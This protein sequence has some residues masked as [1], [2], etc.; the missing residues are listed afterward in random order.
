MKTLFSSILLISLLIQPAQEPLPA[1]VLPNPDSPMPSLFA[2]QLEQWL[3]D[4]QPGGTHIYAVMSYRLNMYGEFVSLAGLDP[5]TPPPYPWSL[6]DGTNLRWVGTLKRTDGQFALYPTS[7]EI[8]ASVHGAGPGGGAEISFPWQS[9]AKMLFGP[10]G[11]HGGGLSISSGVGIDWVGGN[12]L[13]AGVASDVVY[14]SAGGE[15]TSVCE[16][17]TSL[18]LRIEG[19]GNTFGYLHLDPDSNLEQGMTVSAGQALGSLKHGSFNDTCGWADQTANHY[20]L[21]WV[22]QPSAGKYLAEGWVLKDGKWTRGNQSVA[23]NQYMLGGSGTGGGDDDPPG[24][25]TIVVIPGE[26]V[27]G[28]G[29]R[30]WDYFIMAVNSAWGWV[31]PKMPN[32]D[33]NLARLNDQMWNTAKEIANDELETINVVAVNDTFYILPWFILAFL[34]LGFE[35]IKNMLYIFV[36]A[37]HTFRNLK[38]TFFI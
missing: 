16:D 10:R 28:G 18:G 23:V 13:G 17:G 5:E 1:L 11:V 19:G 9:G 38:Q 22:I 7:S 33:S 32:P 36:W 8:T 24:G 29:Y 25:S 26:D 31:K 21:H 3:T 30:I 14:A 27:V 20:H 37:W 35:F 12:D 6:E 4:Y 2:Y 15:I 34:V